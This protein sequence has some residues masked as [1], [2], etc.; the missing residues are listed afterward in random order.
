[1][2]PTRNTLSEKIRAQSI[3]LP[4]PGELPNPAELPNPG[5]LCVANSG[6]AKTATTTAIPGAA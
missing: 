5:R 3:E 1:M 4:N 2:Q 6:A